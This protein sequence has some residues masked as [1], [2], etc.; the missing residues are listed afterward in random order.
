MMVINLLLLKGKEA[1]TNVICRLHETLRLLCYYCVVSCCIYTGL[2]ELGRE[3]GKQIGP[4]E[5]WNH[6]VG[7]E[8]GKGIKDGKMPI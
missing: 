7:E 4:G 5:E 8:V 6:H 1:C 2:G 3:L